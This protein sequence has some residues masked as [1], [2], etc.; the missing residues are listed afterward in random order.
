MTRHTQWRDWTYRNRDPARRVLHRILSLGTLNRG[1]RHAGSCAFTSSGEGPSAPDHAEFGRLQFCLQ[2]LWWF[3]CFQDAPSTWAILR[4]IAHCYAQP[5]ILRSA[6]RCPC[7]LGA[8]LL[9][10]QP[11]ET[12]RPERTAPRAQSGWSACHHGIISSMERGPQPS[13]REKHAGR[14]AWGGGGKSREAQPAR[15]LILS[16]RTFEFVD[17]TPPPQF[18]F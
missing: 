5:H 16:L 11:T 8:E 15:R 12:E 2:E 6:R 4:N 14:C 9:A 1:T 7:T 17:V 18:Y 3:H 10:I 13:E